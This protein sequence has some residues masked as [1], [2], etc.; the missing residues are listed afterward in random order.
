MPFPLTEEDLAAAEAALSTRFPESYRQKMMLD[1]GGEV[2]AA[3]D[4][5]ELFKVLDRTDQKRLARTSA[6]ELVRENNAAH[7]WDAFPPTGV[8]IGDNGAGDYL[9]FTRGGDALRREVSVWDHETGEITQ[10]ADD[11]ADLLDG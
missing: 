4:G 7:A 5:F 11:F 9:L 2:E 1:N 8:A 10:V 6:N 3:G